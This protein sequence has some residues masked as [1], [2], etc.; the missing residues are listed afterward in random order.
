VRSLP[1]VELTSP[2]DWIPYSADFAQREELREESAAIETR[3]AASVSQIADECSIEPHFRKDARYIAAAATK[4]G[5][6]D[7]EF[8]T[9][10][11]A[12]VHVASDDMTGDGFK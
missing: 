6:E 3:K 11:V 9:R 10:L 1:H 7:D 2:K 5:S 8:A 12:S 4:R